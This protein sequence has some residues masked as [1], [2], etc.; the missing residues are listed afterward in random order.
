[1]LKSSEIKLKENEE[2]VR[3]LLDSTAEAIY[4]IDLDG[5]CTFVNPRCLEFLG[6]DREEDLLG[7]EMHPLIHHTKSDG[8]QYPATECKIYEIFKSKN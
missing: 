7:K 6:Y 1:M 3:L 8:T 4:G 2:Q 5:C